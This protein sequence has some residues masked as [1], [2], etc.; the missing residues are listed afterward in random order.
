MANLSRKQHHC[1]QKE[2]IPWEILDLKFALLL[3]VGM[4]TVDVVKAYRSK[5]NYS[6]IKMLNVIS[7]EANQ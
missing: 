6:A 3:L 2:H 4:C 7:S 1:F 5:M